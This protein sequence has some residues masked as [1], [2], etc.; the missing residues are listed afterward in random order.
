MDEST[1]GHWELKPWALRPWM[2]AY[3]L[4]PLDF[5]DRLSVIAGLIAQSCGTSIDE[6]SFMQLDVPHVALRSELPA[7]AWM[8]VAEP[9]IEA[10]AVRPHAPV[11]IQHGEVE[12]LEDQM[13]I[14]RTP[15]SSSS[16]EHLSQHVCLFHLDDDPVYGRIDWGDYQVMMHDAA[17]LLGV[18]REH[19][20]GLIDVQ[21]PVHDLAGRC[22]SLDCADGR[23]LGPR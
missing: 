16:S 3:H 10:Q 12:N 6:V 13:Q 8:D 21:V 23:R 11:V 20:L 19:L 7:P 18:P 1:L 22:G 17:I 14:A 9:T 5:N 15:S 4:S 2:L